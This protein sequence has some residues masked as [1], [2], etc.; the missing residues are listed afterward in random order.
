M[1]PN[2][3]IIYLKVEVASEGECSDECT[4]PKVVDPVCGSDGQTYSNACEAECVDVSTSQRCSLYHS[5]EFDHFFAFR[6]LW[7]LT[8]NVPG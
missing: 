2:I 5:E 8:A 3:K 6:S 7:H 4:C 1:S